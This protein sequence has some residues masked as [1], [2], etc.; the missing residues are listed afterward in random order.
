M[1]LAL[2][3]DS[4]MLGSTKV[5]ATYVQSCFNMPAVLSEL[6]CCVQ[7][8]CKAV[9]GSTS[10]Q[11]LYGQTPITKT[12]EAEMACSDASVVCMNT[13][14][15]DAFVPGLGVADHVWCYREFTRIA[16]ANGK[17]MVFMT[18][19]PIDDPHN[20]ALWEQQH[21]LRALA[22]SLNVPVIDQYGAIGSCC[23]QWKTMLPDK[24]HPN[25]DLYRFMGHVAYM[26]MSA[27]LKGIQ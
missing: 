19:N 6:L 3:G 14:I 24:I 9:G 13:G 17:T 12:W 2:Y 1:K 25:D 22:V 21:N 18:P 23:P 7:V 27:V 26:G 11:W 10:G 20:G 8:E 5:G 4:T 15:N 16:R